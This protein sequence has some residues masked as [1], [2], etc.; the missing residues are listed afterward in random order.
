ME[1]RTLVE[2]DY[3]ELAKQANNWNIA[4][5]LTDMFP[6]PY[7]EDDAKN[8]LKDAAGNPE[9]RAIT[10]EGRFAGVIS[11]TK[12]GKNEDHEAGLGYWLGEE[13]WGKGL[14][15][16]A[17]SNFVDEYLTENPDIMRLQA[18]VYPHNPGSARVLEKNGFQYEGTRRFGTKQRG[19][20]LDEWVYSYIR[21]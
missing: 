19:R 18:K 6:H 4:E 15:S 7:T 8:F 9:F 10:Y 21:E 17:V 2:S 16:K 3:E 11:A 5:N 20:Y 13:F 14:M 1:L 12:G